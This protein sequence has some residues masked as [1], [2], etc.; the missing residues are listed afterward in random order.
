LIAV[1]DKVMR[2]DIV[3]VLW[4]NIVMKTVFHNYRW[5]DYFRH[6]MLPEQRH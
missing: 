6:R 5:I 3:T 4:L 2:V 1:I